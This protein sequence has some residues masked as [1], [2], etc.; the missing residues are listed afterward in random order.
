MSCDDGLLWISDSHKIF[1]FCFW[2]YIIQAF[3]KHVTIIPPWQPNKMSDNKTKWKLFLQNRLLM[4]AE[5]FNLVDKVVF[6]EDYCEKLWTNWVLYSIKCLIAMFSFYP[7]SDKQKHL[8][9]I[10][11]ACIS[12][13]ILLSKT[14]TITSLK[15]ILQDQSC[16]VNCS[17]EVIYWNL[18]L[19]PWNLFVVLMSFSSIVTCNLWHNL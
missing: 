9:D 13:C 16:A 6:W 3:S 17:F 10:H 19:I 2:G 18:T 15:Q 11:S 14:H 7:K 4:M 5:S 12:I 8:W 1:L